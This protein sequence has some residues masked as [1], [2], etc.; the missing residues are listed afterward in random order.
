MTTVAVYN[1][2]WE[3]GG[4]GEMF[5]GGIAQA[6]AEAGHDVTVL[7]HRDFDVDALSERLS[8]DL[9]GCTLTTVD[10]GATAVSAASA[11]FDLFVNGSY[12][13][14]VVNRAAHGLYVV[15]F[16]SRPWGRDPGPLARLYQSR[17]VSNDIE[18]EWGEGFH[19]P[20]GGSGTVWTAGEATIYVTSHASAPK[21]INLLFGRSREAAAGPVDVQVR[22][23][24]ESAGHVTIA[25]SAASLVDRVR[26]RLPEAVPIVVPPESRSEI[27][28]DSDTFVP[29]ALG[30]G[31]D[32]RTL[33]VRFH[34]IEIRSP[35]SSLISRVFPSL[36][37]RLIQ[38]NTTG[39][40]L[41]SYDVV[42]SNSEFTQGFVQEWWG[43]DESPV[44]YPPVHLR[45][46]ASGKTQTIAAVGRFFEKDAGHSKKQLELVKAFRRL[47]ATGV[48]GW[49]LELVG[50]VDASARGY[51]EEVERAAAGLPI[52]FHANAA[53][54]V[55]D[56]IL[57]KASI[58]WHATGFG[59]DPASAPELME[60][61]GISTVE[62]MS[63][64]A[65][66]VVFGGGGQNE[67]VRTDAGYRF[68]RL[69]ELV[70]I[71]RSLIEDD[72]RRLALAEG[73]AER[74]RDFGFDRFSE[75]LH[76]IVA[77][78]MEDDT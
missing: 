9:S 26:N 21:E 72:E 29:E 49:S 56:E 16:P 61:F 31:S 34:G 71:T 75:R 43:L 22:V 39:A 58:F 65:V 52:H 20:D 64:G 4:G 73:A 3:T 27:T 28:I 47:L 37:H 62:A 55:R 8:L 45:E 38:K 44:L 51:F 2:Y 19:E 69:D 78:I 54:S 50:G 48:E 24:G 15:H 46:P 5:C 33:G 57:S 70:E 13:S 11:E 68:S 25:G 18:F 36:N 10:V 7:A 17:F 12:L 1:E 30:L 6:L 67:I 14:P 42:V 35:V 41:R 40:F 32:R 59:E 63:T 53:G 77:S 23:N 76:E 60:H 74:A 66:P